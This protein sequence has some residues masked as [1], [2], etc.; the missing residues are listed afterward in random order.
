M[1]VYVCV[2]ERE[3]ERLREYSERG[4][5]VMDKVTDMGATA[6]NNSSDFVSRSQPC[7]LIANMAIGSQAVQVSKN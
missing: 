4:R 6:A 1:C 7:S 3:K 2:R 5:P